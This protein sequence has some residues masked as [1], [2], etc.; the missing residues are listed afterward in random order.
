MVTILK[1]FHLILANLLFFIVFSMNT[2]ID[3]KGK[4]NKKKKT[5]RKYTREECFQ[6][7]FKLKI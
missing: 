4:S 6:E 5:L 3:E 2:D 1:T 7:Y